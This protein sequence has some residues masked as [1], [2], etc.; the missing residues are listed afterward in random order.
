MKF[1]T[2]NTTD[3]WG[4]FFLKMKIILFLSSLSITIGASNMW[5]GGKLSSGRNF[6]W[7][8]KNPFNYTNWGIQ[9]EQPSGDGDCIEMWSPWF[10]DR[11]GCSLDAGEI[12]LYASIF[13]IYLN[14]N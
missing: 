3:S 11:M 1:A 4:L 9:T 13:L 12:L 14:L 2:L 5:I 10:A 8:D 6:E 7:I